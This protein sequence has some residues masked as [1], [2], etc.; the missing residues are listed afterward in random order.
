VPYWHWGMLG[1]ASSDEVTDRAK[2]P[3]LW[4]DPG[5]DQAQTRHSALKN[6][7]T[8]NVHGL[9][10][11]WS[12]SSGTLRGHEGQPLVVDLGGTPNDVHGKRLAKHH[13]G[14]GSDRP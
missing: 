14:T 2:N 7:N 11:V 13:P 12:Q 10:M 1:L 8:Q 9:Q 5:G 4:A 6:I 3:D